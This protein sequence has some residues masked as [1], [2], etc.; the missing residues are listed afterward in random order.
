MG[1][2]GSPV[3]DIMGKEYYPPVKDLVNHPP[4]YKYGDMEI[5]DII[6]EKSKN[7]R[8]NHYDFGI[9]GQMIQYLFRFDLKGDYKTDLKKARFYLDALIREEENR[10]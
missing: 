6:K 5:L 1:R 10:N 8:M 2:Q 3:K 4:H 9:W 7:T